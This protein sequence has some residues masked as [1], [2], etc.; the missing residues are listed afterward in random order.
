MAN[1]WFS[2]K[3]KESLWRGSRVAKGIRL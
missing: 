3:S 2:F 1:V